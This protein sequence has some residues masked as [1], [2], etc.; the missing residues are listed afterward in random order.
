MG[1]GTG[2]FRLH[3]AVI[4]PTR[5]GPLLALARGAL[6]LAAAPYGLA[7]EVR[8]ALYRVGLARVHRPEVPV[9]SVGNITVGGTGK[10]PLVAWLARLMV[11]CKRRPAILSRGYGHSDAL[12]VDDENQMLARLA[13]DV[14]IVVDPDR[15]RG[16]EKAIRRHGA[17]VLI[18]DDGFQHRRIARDLDIVLVDALWPFGAGHLLP[19]GLLR[20]PLRALRRADFLL[21]TRA[22]LSG[23]DPVKEIR[24][25]LRRLAPGVPTACCAITVR[26]LRPL[27]GADALPPTELKQGRWAAFCGVGNPEGF[28]STLREAGCDP[29]VMAVFPD[30]AR[31]TRRQ[32]EGVLGRA[33]EAGCDRVVTTE[34]DATKVE[35]LLEG[36]AAPPVYALQTA[37]DFTEGSEALAAAILAAVER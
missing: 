1:I 7:V 25:R 15:A 29:A 21:I 26:G 2:L 35:R 10:T 4:S 22:N 9:I 5:R 14:P 17:D 30:H 8:S 6:R 37:L 16:A 18:L 23:A 34:K 28:L 11:I 32:V 3:R 12:G 31:Y 36:A 33:A 24:S 19:R 13:P 27:K 20:E